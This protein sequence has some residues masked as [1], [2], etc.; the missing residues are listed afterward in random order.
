V[1]RIRILLG[2]NSNERLILHFH[3]LGTV[4]DWIDP[5]ERNYWCDED[6]F[7]A[8]LDFICTLRE[9]VQIE[10]TFDDGNISDAIVALPALTDRGLIASF[11]VCAGRIGLPGYLDSS[12]MNDIISCGMA[13]GSHGWGHVDWRR[14]DDKTLDV[15][16]DEARKAIGDV[17]GRGIDTVAIPFGSYD[18]RIVRRLRRSKIKTVFTSDGG[19]AALAGWMLPREAFRTSWTN[20]T[21]I[22]MATR[23]LS[24]RVRMRRSVVGLIKR[25]R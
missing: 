15:E 3:G 23:P 19:R 1:E 24:I 20:S 12:A 9:V 16:I 25:L 2:V 10:L 4:P 5:E 13:I 8:I 18:R 21:L 14:A 22:E 11:F 6:R 7:K 17:L